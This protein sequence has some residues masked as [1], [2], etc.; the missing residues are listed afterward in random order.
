MTKYKF[1]LIAA[2]AILFTG[3]AKAQTKIDGEPVDGQVRIIYEGSAYSD[4]RVSQVGTIDCIIRVTPKISLETIATGGSYFNQQY[5]GGGIAATFSAKDSYIT[6]G[7][8][9]NSQTSTQAI[10]GVNAE[11]GSVIGRSNGFIKAVEADVVF[12]ARGYDIVPSY[13]MQTYT[14]RG[15]AYFK[16]GDFM[17]R[18]GALSTANN[19][20]VNVTPTGGARL[21]WNWTR[22]FSTT[23]S[24][25]VDAETFTNVFNIQ[26]LSSRNLG[27]G[28]KYYLNKNTSI[29]A[30][31]VT[32]HFTSAN[33]TGNA[34]SLVL[35]K[36]F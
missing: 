34:F 36:S 2:L 35:Q 18:I 21:R 8:N 15:I 19:N 27:G 9:R 14:V 24:A 31:G 5:G 11:G 23:V 32:M 28:I 33:L 16:R 20:L 3:A 10:W 7:T 17:I 12:N 6:I 1:I 4:G 13:S 25:G 29:E 26:N 30:Q 22:R